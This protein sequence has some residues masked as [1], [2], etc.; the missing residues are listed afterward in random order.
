[1]LFDD[2]GVPWPI[3]AC[4]EARLS[5]R[6]VTDRAAYR[7]YMVSVYGRPFVPKMLNRGRAPVFGSSRV[8]RKP[9]VQSNSPVRP[10]DIDRCNASNFI[11]AV[12]DVTGFVHDFHSALSITRFA[13]TGSL[14]YSV[15][16]K[17]IGAN[18][19]S[20]LTVIDGDLVSYTVVVPNVELKLSLGSIVSLRIEAV[21]TIRDALFVCRSLNLVR[22]QSVP[23][24]AT[25][26]SGSTTPFADSNP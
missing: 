8:T 21:E 22:I 26:D 19:Y 12:L 14:G 3:H 11:G 1:M 10:V 25:N 13:S 23:E 15:Y 2:L 5:G 9:P 7:A 16:E 4:Y 17:V 24:K 20:Q 18:N 6:R